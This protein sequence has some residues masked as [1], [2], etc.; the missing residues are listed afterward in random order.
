LFGLGQAL[1]NRRSKKASSHRK[2]QYT[3]M[4][5]STHDD[6][7]LIGFSMKAV[8]VGLCCIFL[9]FGTLGYF[10]KIFKQITAEN[11]ELQYVRDIAEEQRRQIS[12]LQQYYNSLNERLRQA[13]L[14]ES[15]IRE[16]LQGENIIPQSYE[17][18]NAIIASLDARTISLTSRDSLV[19]SGEL[20]SAD[21]E[22]ILSLLASGFSQIA[23]ET[24]MLEEATEKLMEDAEKAVDYHRAQPS[25][26]PVK[27]RVTSDFGWRRHPIYGNN[28]FH[29]A[30][31]IAGSSW[32]PILATADGTVA[33]AG[34]RSG[35]GYTVT[36]DHGYGMRTLYAHCISIAVK[37]NQSVARGEV[38]AYVGQSGTATG[39]H[40]HYEVHKDGVAVNPRLYFPD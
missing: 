7:K 35:Y 22:R 2:R 37:K 14:L 8:F 4:L 16:M 5:V 31:D 13:E 36:I 12:E 6:T 30:L 40:L 27:G 33:F 21:H 25:I 24:A 9:A 15:Q 38:I 28:E 19:G 34:Y 29:S 18:G 10:I 26:W 39:P 3:L 17:E 1:K 32:D 23:Q 20:R 11:S